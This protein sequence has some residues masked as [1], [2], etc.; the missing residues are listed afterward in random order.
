ML[1]R[2]KQL[3]KEAAKKSNSSLSPASH[4]T[5]TVPR[6]FDTAPDIVPRNTLKQPVRKPS[7]FHP[8]NIQ[9]SSTPMKDATVRKSAGDDVD[10]LLLDGENDLPI[11]GHRLSSGSS[12]NHEHRQLG[13]I[14][15]FHDTQE[16]EMHS[17]GDLEAVGVK[18]C[19]KRLFGNEATNMERRQ[20]Q[21]KND[22]GK[23]EPV[24][25]PSLTQEEG[26][27]VGVLETNCELVRNEPTSP[28]SCRSLNNSSLLQ[29]RSNCDCSFSSGIGKL[30]T[31]LPRTQNVPMVHRLL[32]SGDDSQKLFAETKARMAS[33]RTNISDFLQSEKTRTSNSSYSCKPIL[34]NRETGRAVDINSHLT[35]SRTS[36][37]G[38]VDESVENVPADIHSSRNVTVS[39]DEVAC[40]SADAVVKET[41]SLSCQNVSK[42]ANCENS[43][44]S[45]AEILEQSSDSRENRSGGRVTSAPLPD[46]SCSGDDIVT[47]DMLD[48]LKARIKQLKLRQD[49]LERDQ[50]LS[51]KDL[52][53][54]STTNPFVTSSIG[55][56]VTQPG[57][58]SSS[59]SKQGVDS[60]SSGVPVLNKDDEVDSTRNISARLRFGLQRTSAARSLMFEFTKPSTS[61]ESF[62]P[63][64]FSSK[65]GINGHADTAGLTSTSYYRLFPESQNLVTSFGSNH[66]MEMESYMP[67]ADAHSGE[68]R[69]LVGD[70]LTTMVVDASAGSNGLILP[71]IYSL[72][73]PVNSVPGKP[74]GN[75]QSCILSDNLSLNTLIPYT[76]SANLNT[77][78]LST[79]PVCVI[80]NSET[81][82]SGGHADRSV[83]NTVVVSSGN[84]DSISSAAL[85]GEN[86]LSSNSHKN[87]QPFRFVASNPMTLGDADSTAADSVLTSDCLDIACRAVEPNAITSTVN[88]INKHTSVNLAVTSSQLLGKQTVETSV[89]N[90][91][92]KAV[93][94]LQRT[95]LIPAEPCPRDGNTESL[96]DDAGN[97]PH[98]LNA[99]VD[100]PG[101]A[102]GSDMIQQSSEDEEKQKLRSVI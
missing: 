7:L 15:P 89:A 63:P 88:D 94:L 57:Y 58:I 9:L 31:Q 46:L 36:D 67:A 16:H 6:S 40:L 86:S 47:P 54:T 14:S 85:A 18:S 19:G 42:A 70:S 78:S 96:R 37:A 65:P 77:G 52:L 95:A 99:L 80:S 53:A 24:G 84:A 49:Q 72:A 61:S 29:P 11:S 55:A 59:D 92:E 1:C 62:K 13:R 69:K 50:L 76:R 74:D 44:R 25:K 23:S 48:S 102:H 20:E 21:A 68:V 51:T 34:S 35:V 56:S 41:A 73:V 83:A 64:V 79:Q 75:L 91:R 101:S 100:L 71:S 60:I 98:V 87:P 33:A 97:S 26:K 17:V 28:C 39:L 66:Q 90:A 27:D 22:D 2:V 30:G 82:L 45:W 4:T 93:S 38:Y 43:G 5:A 8:S 81:I 12:T 10:S 3:T 32:P